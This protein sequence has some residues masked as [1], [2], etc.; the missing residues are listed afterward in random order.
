MTCY[1]RMHTGIDCFAIVDN[2]SDGVA[3]NDID[4]SCDGATVNEVDGD[5]DSVMGKKVDDDCNGATGYD[6]KQQ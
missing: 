2:D 6:D 1:P 5:C 4:N 3:G